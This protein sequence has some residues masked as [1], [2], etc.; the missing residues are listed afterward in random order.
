MIMNIQIRIEETEQSIKLYAPYSPLNNKD[1]KSRGGRWDKDSSAW[2]FPKT[3]ATQ[4]ML[5]ELF[6]AP[7]EI[8]T[9]KVEYKD[10]EVF[11]NFWQCGGYVVASRRGRDYPARIADGVQVTKGQ[12][13][14]SCGSAKNPKVG[15]SSD[16]LEFSL[17]CY[18]SFAE[19]KKL[20]IVS[21]DSSFNP[22]AAFSDA[23]LLAEIKRRGL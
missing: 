21:V 17:V 10:I 18:R 20:E 22:L 23:Q 6:G 9:A 2:V 3:E 5:A 19:S 8:V 15:Y 7:S 12:F 13:R 4:K 1:Y 11:E 16:G 14:D